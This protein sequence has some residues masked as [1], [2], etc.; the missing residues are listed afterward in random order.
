M[1]I[2][3]FIAALMAIVSGTA[4]AATVTVTYTEPAQT[5]SGSPITN[6]KETAIFWKQ[7]AKA[8]VKIV[9]PA[10]KP[11]GGGAVSRVITI[12]DPPVCGLTT[13]VVSATASD[14]AG[15]ESARATPVSATRDNSKTAECAKAKP[16]TNLTIII[17]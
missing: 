14:T 9:V 13:V 6:L 11:T 12:A 5:V 8:E 16:P 15:N 2:G 3:I 10:S 17:Q 7:D 4:M 1:H